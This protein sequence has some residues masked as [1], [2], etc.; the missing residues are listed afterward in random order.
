MRANIIFTLMCAA[1]LLAPPGLLAADTEAD[2]YPIDFALVRN[3]SG[4]LA[5]VKFP[6]GLSLYV[7]DKDSEGKSN[8]TLG[9]AGAHP[10]VIAKD[11]AEP[12]GHW[13]PIDRDD[14]TKQWAYKGRPVY[15]YY[16]DKP[17]DPQGAGD[18]GWNVLQL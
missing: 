18:E 6:E 17:G 3:S 1:V 15:L 2:A 12:I 16:H 4:Q 13:I 5:F 10:P 9:C 14:G 7:Y 8:C 11:D